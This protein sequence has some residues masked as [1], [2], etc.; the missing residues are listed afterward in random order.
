VPAVELLRIEFTDDK[1]CRLAFWRYQLQYKWAV[2]YS[3]NEYWAQ[4]WSWSLGS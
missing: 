1:I 3:I 2:P 4:S